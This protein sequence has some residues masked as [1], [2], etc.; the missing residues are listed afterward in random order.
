[1]H[2][3][4]Y[5][6]WTQQ[7]F[8]TEGVDWTFFTEG[9]ETLMSRCIQHFLPEHIA[10]TISS[11]T[12]RSR[13]YLQDVVCACLTRDDA[14]GFL[15]FSKG[16]CMSLIRR[17]NAWFDAPQNRFNPC[18]VEKA[19]KMVRAAGHH[20]FTFVLPKA[21]VDTVLL[22]AITSH[23]E[24]VLD[25]F[26]S[27]DTLTDAIVRGDLSEDVTDVLL[28]MRCKHATLDDGQKALYE[29]VRREKD[30]YSLC[31]ERALTIVELLRWCIRDSIV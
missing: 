9:R 13:P 3:D 24:N 22:P 18:G 31:S 27:G 4:S 12:L 17:G 21:A 28:A 7:S 5:F 16:H 19:T 25:V 26:S 8:Y 15:Y 20:G 10:F 14:R 30:A 23:I 29:A 2:N 11:A 6:N 1:M